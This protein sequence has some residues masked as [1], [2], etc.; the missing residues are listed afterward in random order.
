[1]DPPDVE[2]ERPNLAPRDH[3]TDLADA[4]GIE[5]WCIRNITSAKAGTKVGQ[6]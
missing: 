3:Q 6:R 4:R 1:M 2:L 5:A